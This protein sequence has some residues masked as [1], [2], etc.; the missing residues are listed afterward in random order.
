MPWCRQAPNAAEAACARFRH[1]RWCE[2]HHWPQHAARRMGVAMVSK[3][4]KHG[5]STGALTWR[6]LLP[7]GRHTVLGRG[8]HPLRLARCTTTGH[9]TAHPQARRPLQP[10]PVTTSY[11]SRGVDSSVTTCF[12]ALG[13]LMGPRRRRACSQA[14][15]SGRN[16]RQAAGKGRRGLAHRQSSPVDARRPSLRTD[17]AGRYQMGERRGPHTTT[18]FLST[19]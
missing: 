9:V 18:A 17:A 15:G 12:S 8:A 2:E 4:G 5:S 6:R 16:V 11:L 3:P 1:S 13:S 19:D 14:G 10:P 7:D